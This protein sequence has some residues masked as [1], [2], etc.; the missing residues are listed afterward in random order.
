M[1]IT[2]R[3]SRL[4]QQSQRSERGE[5]L[6]VSTKGRYALR[7]LI[8]LA[9][10]QQNG[11][12]SLKDIAERQNISKQYLEQIIPLLNTSNILRANRGKLGG[13]MLAREPSQYTAGQILQITEGSMA[14]VACLDDDVNK[15]E[16]ADNCSTLPMWEGLNRVIADY[17]NGITLQDMLDQHLER[18]ANNYVI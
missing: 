7:M 18:G 1:W 14:P 4:T 8:D 9:E 16:R 10:H 6:K 17:L 13:Y 11:F 12:V 15:C 2:V 5:R 3:A